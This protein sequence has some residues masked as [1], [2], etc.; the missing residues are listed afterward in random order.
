M[1]RTLGALVLV[2]FGAGVLAVAWRGYRSGVLPA[3]SAGWKPYR[4]TRDDTP[5]AFHFFLVLYLCGGM[6]LAV[7]GLLALF[8]LAAAPELS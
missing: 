6:A 7:W 5:V 8:G 4:P 2:L 1:P 3:G